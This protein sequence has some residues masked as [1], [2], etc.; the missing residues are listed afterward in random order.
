MVSTE[1]KTSHF[2]ICHSLQI[3]VRIKTYCFLF[4]YV[5]SLTEAEFENIVEETLDSLAEFLENLPEVINCSD[6]FDITLGVS[7]SV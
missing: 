5:Y 2:I 1:A 3:S 7:F 4:V 6:D